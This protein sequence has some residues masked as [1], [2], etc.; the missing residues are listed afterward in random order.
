[1]AFYYRYPNKSAEVVPQ[2]EQDTLLKRKGVW[3]G[4][5]VDWSG[6]IQ[7]VAITGAELSALQRKHKT[8]DINLRRATAV[9]KAMLDGKKQAQIVRQLRTMGHGY[10]E[11]MIKADHAALLPFVK[12]AQ[13]KVQ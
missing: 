13:K 11:R 12:N 2:E 1:M 4:H 5:V 8:T 3:D 6:D 9:K 7:S 10:G